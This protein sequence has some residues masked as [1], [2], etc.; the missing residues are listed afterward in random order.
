[1]E[2]TVQGSTL[3]SKCKKCGSGLKASEATV[4]ISPAVSQCSHTKSIEQCINA[5]TESLLRFGGG[6]VKAFDEVFVLQEHVFERHTQNYS[7]FSSILMN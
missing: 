6:E 4:A 2:Y 3:D 7:H 5:C 1:M